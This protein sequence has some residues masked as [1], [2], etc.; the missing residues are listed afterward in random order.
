VLI[1]RFST[2]TTFCSYQSF[3]IF[4]YLSHFFTL[5]LYQVIGSSAS[6]SATQS[7]APGGNFSSVIKDVN[8]SLEDDPTQRELHA[9]ATEVEERHVAI[10]QENVP[11]VVTQQEVSK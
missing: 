10:A 2:S 4:F 8:R 5:P 9:D 1:N 3:L 7:S 11:S 6:H